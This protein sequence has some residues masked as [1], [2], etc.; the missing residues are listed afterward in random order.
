[1]PVRRDFATCYRAVRPILDKY[2]RRGRLGEVAP[3]LGPLDK[4][5]Y[6]VWIGKD[7]PA[8]R[9]PLPKTKPWHRSAVHTLQLLK[10][11]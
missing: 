5:G 8:T 11:R 6:C 1:M 10:P 3:I 4:I 7:G 9:F 2:V